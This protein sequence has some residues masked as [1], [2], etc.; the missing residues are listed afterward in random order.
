MPTKWLQEPTNGSKND[1][2]RVEKVTWYG[3]LAACSKFVT[4]FRGIRALTLT[5]SHSH[6]S[7]SL[8]LTHSLT[9]SLSLTLTPPQRETQRVEKV[10]WY[11]QLAACSKFGPCSP[12]APHSAEQ[13]ANSIACICTTSRWIPAS[14]STNQGPK[15]KAI[16]AEGGEGDVV[17]AAGRML[18]VRG[19]LPR[20]P[21]EAR[22]PRGSHGPPPR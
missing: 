12:R 22:G 10:T 16:W 9:H 19:H 3:Q 21:R 1:S 11:G 18:E 15:K 6:S 20:H 2:Q 7:L 8:T 4:M 17:R 5:H 14:A 13:I